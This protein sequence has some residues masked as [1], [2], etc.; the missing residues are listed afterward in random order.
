MDSGLEISSLGFWLDAFVRRSTE[1]VYVTPSTVS[2]ARNYKTRRK[3]TNLVSTS[4]LAH[5]LAFQT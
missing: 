3:L 5:R 1:N 2:S 4:D